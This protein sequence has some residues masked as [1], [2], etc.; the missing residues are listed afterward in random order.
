MPAELKHKLNKKL[1]V[2]FKKYFSAGQLWKKSE[3]IEPL[4]ILVNNIRPDS[5]TEPVTLKPLIEIL[6]SNPQYLE[7]FRLYLSQLFK[8]RS[9]TEMITDVGITSNDSFGK[10]F[11]RKIT[12]QILP[13]TSDAKKLRF[14]FSQVFYNKMDRAWVYS[15]SRIQLLELLNLLNFDQIENQFD[16]EKPLWQIYYATVVIA[17]RACGA[18]LEKNIIRLAP[19]YEKKNSAFLGLYKEIEDLWEKSSNQK[20]LISQE[21]D[22]YKQI[23]VLLNQ[24]HEYLNQVNKG[25]EQFGISLS[26][27]KEL[28][29]IH[30]Q[31]D[32]IELILPLLAQENENLPQ[33]KLMN[34]FYVLMDIHAKRKKLKTFISDSTRLLAFEISSHKAK[35]GEKY[36]SHNKREYFEMLKA[37]LGGGFVVGVLCILKLLLGKISTSDFGHAFLYSFNYAAGFVAIYLLGYTLATKQPAMTASTL[38][39]LINKGLNTNVRAKYKYKA[40][41]GYFARLF[42]TQFI[43]F[44]GNVVMA[45]PVA[46]LGIYLIYIISG[47][48]IVEIKAD[49]LLKDLSP[50]HSWAIFHAAIAGFFLFLSGIISGNVANRN[51]FYNIYKR[52]EDNPGMK[53]SIGALRAKRLSQWYS[54]KWPG[55]MSNVWFGIFMGSTASIGAFLGL[56]LDVRHITFAAGNLGM[57]V[58]GKNWNISPEIWLWSII[59]IGVIGFTNFMVSFGLSLILAFKSRNIPAKEIRP[60]LLSIFQEFK[61]KPITFFFP[62][63]LSTKDKDGEKTKN[64]LEA[65]RD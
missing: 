13:E 2:I 33:V 58:F 35:T 29:R 59:G 14:I 39:E 12:D 18:A 5:I 28:Y 60:I 9:F 55:I 65:L 25:A 49:Y 38:V 46:L 44:V 11:L 6:K 50:V 43:A 10:E 47:I 63:F 3:P 53:L 64:T 19:Q 7:N 23:I 37:S 8:N 57:A 41:A 4:M 42:R 31:L 54:T 48:D 22:D 30:E 34:L 52:L 21:D 56:N 62:F 17:L 1:P 36:I 51:K 32:R 24:C 40:F 61:S 26:T 15:I 45:F 16:R 27:N 20:N